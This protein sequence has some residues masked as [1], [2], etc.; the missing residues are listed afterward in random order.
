MRVNHGGFN[1]AVSEQ[2]LHR[3]NVIAVL[4]QVSGKRVPQR[5]RGRTLADAG[6]LFRTSRQQRKLTAPFGSRAKGALSLT[7]S[8]L[9]APESMSVNAVPW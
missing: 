8:K 6:S 3:A 9:I 7:Q 1:A 4:K 5:M 2:L